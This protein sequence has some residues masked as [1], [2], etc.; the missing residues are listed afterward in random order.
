[1]KN[2]NILFVPDLDEGEMH[3]RNGGWRLRHCM[4]SKRLQAPNDINHPLD[5]VRVKQ[6]SHCLIWFDFICS[7]IYLITCLTSQVHFS[8][9]HFVA[10][11]PLN[12]RRV[13]D[14]HWMAKEMM[15]NGSHLCLKACFK[16]SWISLG[17][18]SHS[19]RA[20]AQGGTWSAK[21]G[22]VMFL[23]SIWGLEHIVSHD[24]FSVYFLHKPG[25][26]S[27]MRRFCSV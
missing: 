16:W 24:L 2:D 22:G 14:S 19:R 11:Y 13:K 12:V 4:T 5:Y 6:K 17:V 23:L 10:W 3:T 25:Y 15:G 8:W 21:H 20:L 27:R 26:F 1:M 9:R 7:C 18:D